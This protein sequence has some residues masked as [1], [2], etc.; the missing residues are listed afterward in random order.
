MA[1][2]L[3][4]RIVS[5]DLTDV[6][7]LGPAPSY[8]QRLRGRYR[9]HVLIRGCGLHSFLKDLVMPEGWVVDVDPVTVM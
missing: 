7:V 3:R 8:P 1:R 9:W 6:E 5:E 2:L 4:Q